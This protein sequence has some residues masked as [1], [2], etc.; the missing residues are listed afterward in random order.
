MR[1]LEFL[2]KHLIIKQKKGGKSNNGKNYY[3]FDTNPRKI[4]TEEPDIKHKEKKTKIK[5][6]K[7]KPKQ[8][9]KVSKEQ[10]KKTCK[11]NNVCNI[12]IYSI[13]SH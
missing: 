12:S 5:I 6:V 1:N 3:Q 7:D 9:V 8:Q 10:K 11:T 2:K 13:I 4:Q